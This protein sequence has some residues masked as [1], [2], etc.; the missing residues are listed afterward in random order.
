MCFIRLIAGE[1][2][3]EIGYWVGLP[4]WNLGFA[5]EAALAVVA[6]AGD[7]P[8]IARASDGNDA[9]GRVLANAG[10]V[11]TG[12]SE[13]FCVALGEMSPVTTYHRP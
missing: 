11:E 6:V 7:A 12:R 8:L 2:C 13:A 4:F 1:E 10:F 3:K 5:S 9:S